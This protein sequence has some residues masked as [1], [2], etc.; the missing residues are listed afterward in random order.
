MKILDTKQFNEKLNIQPVS[1]ERLHNTKPYTLKEQLRDWDI[2]LVTRHDGSSRHYVFMSEDGYREND[3]TKLLGLENGGL[4]ISE[5]GALIRKD[6]HYYSR[7]IYLLL[8][9]Y[10][11]NLN[12]MDT[13]K[14]RI[15]IIYRPKELPQ[16]MTKDYFI[17]PP[18]DSSDIIWKRK[19]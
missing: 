3:C 5:D 6:P 15:D 12:R 1:K 10:D 18:F 7:C 16:P 13:I 8:E 2:V 4:P 9:R 19:M 14:Q 17:N 11:D